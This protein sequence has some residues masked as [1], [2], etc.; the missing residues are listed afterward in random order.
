MVHATDRES[1]ALA[2]YI[3]YDVIRHTLAVH[4]A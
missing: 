2:T 1:P 4:P 3:N